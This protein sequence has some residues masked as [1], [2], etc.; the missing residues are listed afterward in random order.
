MFDFTVLQGSR[1][2]ALT[3]ANTIILTKSTA[4]QLFGTT[5]VINKFMRTERVKQPFK[6]TA[7]LEDFPAKLPLKFQSY[8]FTEKFC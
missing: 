3:E 8:Y 1:E 2:N 6:I 7:I 5:D 4:E